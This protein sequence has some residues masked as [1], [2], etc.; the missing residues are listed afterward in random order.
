AGTLNG[1]DL[2]AGAPAAQETRRPPRHVG[3]DARPGRELRASPGGAHSLQPPRLAVHG[4]AAP[5]NRVPAVADSASGLG[6]KAQ[7]G[8]ALLPAADDRGVLLLRALHLHRSG[9]AGA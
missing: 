5:R 3:S 4:V 1:I 9:G 8:S 2:A 7:M 6:R